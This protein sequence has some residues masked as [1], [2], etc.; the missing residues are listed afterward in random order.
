MFGGQKIVARGRVGKAAAMEKM[1][2]AKMSGVNVHVL[3]RVISGTENRIQINS[4]LLVYHEG[5]GITLTDVSFSN[6]NI[7]TKVL[8]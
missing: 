2:R 8:Q 6:I 1:L 7:V 3:R 5:G 4:Q